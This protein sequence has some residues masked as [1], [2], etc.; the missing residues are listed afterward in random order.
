MV[1]CLNCSQQ[2]QHPMKVK[3]EQYKTTLKSI[4]GDWKI[5][6]NQPNHTF[7]RAKGLFKID[8][9]GNV[10]LAIG[11]TNYVRKKSEIIDEDAGQIDFNCAG[12]LTCTAKLRILR[13]HDFVGPMKN[14]FSAA[15]FS[16]AKNPPTVFSAE[17]MLLSAHS[18][19]W[20]YYQARVLQCLE[21]F[22]S[23]DEELLGEM[24][25][26]IGF[27]LYTNIGSDRR[28]PSI[29]VFDHLC[30]AHASEKKLK[31]RHMLHFTCTPCSVSVSLLNRRVNTC[32]LISREADHSRE[33]NPQ[34][35]EY[36]INDQISAFQKPCSNPL[37]LYRKKN[38]LGN[39][40]E[41]VIPDIRTFVTVFDWEGGFDDFAFW[42][43][44]DEKR[45]AEQRLADANELLQ[46]DANELLQ[47][48][49]ECSSEEG[50]CRLMD[51][52][53]LLD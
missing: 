47:M 7:E 37:Y 39:G 38:L 42:D 40:L 17:I 28:R 27:I 35:F 12:L 29:S 53:G 41:S 48:E 52:D 24:H 31:N 1:F 49:E 16:K 5:H 26:Y 14:L 10:R 19:I 32:T 3:Y 51:I 6:H 50:A 36:E 44:D 4:P 30:D 34:T 15:V 20:I 2:L 8:S 43:N 23:Y 21:N 46:I 11:G 13:V 22:R 9:T 33:R 18:C 25:S 45:E